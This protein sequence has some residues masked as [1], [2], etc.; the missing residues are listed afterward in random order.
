MHA[1]EMRGRVVGEARSWIGTPYRH[2]NATKGA[3]ADCAS[4][5]MAVMMACGIVSEDEI[6]HYGFHW[7]VNATEQVYM[8]RVLRHAKL[9]VEGV[10]F[11]T[12]EA[13][14]GDVALVRVMDSRLYN[15]GGIVTKWPRLVHAISPAVEEVN[16]ST[17]CS[18]M[19]ANQQVAIFDPFTKFAEKTT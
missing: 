2:G 17:D 8:T 4:F 10:S 19:W 7:W 5:V 11:P 9:I 3:G 13:Q 1:I 14:P 12:L 6:E 16:A 15:H 18:G